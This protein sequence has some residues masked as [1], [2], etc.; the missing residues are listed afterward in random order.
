MGVELT[1]ATKSGRRGGTRGLNVTIESQ[2]RQQII[3]AARACISEEGVEKLTLRKV[4]E[5]A[6]VSHATIAYYFHTRR[7]LIDDAL[8][9]A[10]EEFM[11][12]LRRRQLFYGT[13][14]L[15]ELVE[16]FLDPSNAS[17]RF[18]VQMIDSGLHDANLRG[19]HQEFIEYGRDRIER[20]LR[21]GIEQGD[22]RADVNPKLAAALL[23][24]VLIWWETELAADATSREMALEVGTLMLDLLR[25]PPPPARS[26]EHHAGAGY[27][28]PRLA[29]NK[30]ASPLEVIAASL[31]D[32]PALSPDAAVTLSESF[33]KLYELAAALSAGSRH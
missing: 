6:R 17:A 1:A 3:E 9:Q 27:G 12:V 5:R 4:A 21:V 22:L 10:S 31:L 15:V 26:A 14:D 8:L 30:P 28:R 13:Q 24:T 25:P 23:H 32:D 11:E 20:S 29:G 7:E 2:R 18:V 19:T 33:Q 16:T